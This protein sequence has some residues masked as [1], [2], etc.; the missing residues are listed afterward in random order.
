MITIHHQVV[1]VQGN[2]TVALEATTAVA[3]RES[4][5]IGWPLDGD[6]LC[7]A[8]GTMPGDKVKGVAAIAS[9]W[10]SNEGER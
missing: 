10:L 3:G 2:V 9:L 1:T 5:G 6:E 8:A 4:C 7:L